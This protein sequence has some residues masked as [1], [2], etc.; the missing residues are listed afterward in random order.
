M[1]M[2]NEMEREERGGDCEKEKNY[3]KTNTDLIFLQATEAMNVLFCLTIG[4]N[5]SSYAKTDKRHS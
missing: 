4:H 3:R 1:Q 2:Q 5:K